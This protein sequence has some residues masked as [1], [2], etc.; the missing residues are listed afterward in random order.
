LLTSHLNHLLQQYWCRSEPYH[1]VS[2]Q[3][4]VAA[5]ADFEIGRLTSAT[6][7]T[8][9]PKE[10]SNPH[11]LVSERYGLKGYELYRAMWHREIILVCR[12]SFLW[13]FR[14]TMVSVEFVTFVI[15]S[16]FSSFSCLLFS[17]FGSVSSSFCA[18]NHL[19]TA[20][21]SGF[22]VLKGAQNPRKFKRSPSL[23]RSPFWNFKSK[24]GT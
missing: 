16:G 17:I 6:L 8:P 20:L 12:N 23:V 4:F 15:K 2:V 24:T 14:A 1:Y 22:H 5:F 11:A 18:S 19:S 13:I 21:E 3:D 10:E 7:A 9:F